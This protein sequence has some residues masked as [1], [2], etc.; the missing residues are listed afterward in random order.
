MLPASFHGPDKPV[1]E[2]SD[3]TQIQIDCANPFSHWCQGVYANRHLPE[4][5]ETVTGREASAL[6]PRS[7]GRTQK[8][9][10]CATPQ[11]DGREPFHR[12]VIDLR[13]NQPTREPILKIGR[14]MAITRPPMVTPRKTS[15]NGSIIAV[16][17]S[18][19]WST[20]SS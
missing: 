5:G 2:C 9:G 16:R 20:S 17:F 6:C 1:R 12:Y 4:T 13:R 18:T 15:I 10:R 11:P 8:P 14:Y 3:N 7:T 19:A